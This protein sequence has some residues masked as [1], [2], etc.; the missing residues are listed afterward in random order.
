MSS[1]VLMRILESA[2]AR[3][4][5]GM[6]LLSLG[7][8]AQR[9]E[10]LAERAAP[11]PGR[12]I[13]ELGCGTGALT[14]RLLE[15]G[16]RVVALDQNPEMLDQARTR[17]GDSVAGKLELHECTAAE[18]DR[19]GEA[20]FDAVAASLVLS[21]MSADERNYVL[22]R[23]ARALRPGGVLVV[24]DE[25]RPRRAWQRCLHALLRTPLALITWLVTGRLSRPVP[26]LGAEV[27][28]AGLRLREERR[29]RLGTYALVV[30][31]RTA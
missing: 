14:A 3:Y 21:E 11:E 2:P 17:L 9:H 4:D 25:V 8:W 5:T 15:R 13:L 23:A 27:S 22:R 28:A 20:Q 31:E 6:R 18:I 19:F 7:A 24:A 26:D 1:L 16:A 12:R 29:S 10:A 30:A